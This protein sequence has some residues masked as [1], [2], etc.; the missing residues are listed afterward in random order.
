MNKNKLVYIANIRIPTEKAHG[1]QIMEMC[2]AFAEQGIEVELVVP[3]RRNS[4]HEDPFVY[5]N[6]PKTFKITKLPSLD[7]IRFGW[8]GFW[9]QQVT[10][11]LSA[12]FY[13]LGRF[14]LC[15]TRDPLI[16]VLFES[17]SQQII[18]E[19]HRGET[20]IL[21]KMLIRMGARMVMITHG[22]KD[23]YVG[24]GA[25]PEN[26][27]VA[28]DAVDM[29][30]FSKIGTKEESRQKSGITS[31]TVILY[32][33]HLYGWKGAHTLADAAKFLPEDIK[34]YFVGGTETDLV[35]FREQ[36]G[37]VKNIEIVGKKPHK[38]MPHYVGS[39]DILVIP[40]SGKEDISKLYTSPM[41]LFEYMAS[42][43]PIIA[44]NLPSIREILN[45]SNAYFFESDNPEDLARVIKHV[46]KDMNTAEQKAKIAL[47][48]VQ[49][50]SW[51][52]RAQII[53]DFF[54]K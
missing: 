20:N 7:L 40:N 2:Q 54:K 26:I 23:L 45:E 52:K 6:L 30:K 46:L 47:Q 38:D 3:H 48:V 24:M 18:W 49:N 37:H 33:G 9:I 29:E 41:K 14:E 39:A 35:L 13:M 53:L 34:I 32:T 44:S 51:D 4:L 10:F 8:I 27:L 42:G 19:G 22:L 1:I 15:Y 43:R 28:P 12:G 21:I 17:L 5:H 16:A 25:R 50:Y 11:A 36:Y 31:R